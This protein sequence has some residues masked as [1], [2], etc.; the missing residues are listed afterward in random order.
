MGTGRGEGGED[1]LLAFNKICDSRRAHMEWVL[2]IAQ[3]DQSKMTTP[4]WSNLRLEITAFCL[5]VGQSAQFAG[6]TIPLDSLPTSEHAGKLV[7]PTNSSAKKILNIFQPVAED[8]FLRKSI[9]LGNIQKKPVLHWSD[10]NN[11]YVHSKITHIGW[12]DQAKDCLDSLIIEFGHLVK[13]CEAPKSR[14]KSD[15]CSIIFL[16]RRPNQVYCSSNC[17]NRATT[18]TSRARDKEGNVSQK[19]KKTTKKSR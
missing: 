15:T 14:K 7:I 10:K 2:E 12:E 18:R 3:L 16:A 17:Q 8:V 19:K 1:Y 9:S 13:R 5:F 4:D 6:L 11:R